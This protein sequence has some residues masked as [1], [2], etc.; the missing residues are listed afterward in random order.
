LML[1][2]C[3]VEERHQENILLEIAGMTYDPSA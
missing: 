3:V 2:I 1:A